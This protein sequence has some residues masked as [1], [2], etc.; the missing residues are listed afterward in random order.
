MKAMDIG[1]VYYDKFFDSMVK[2]KI[3]Y[4]QFK[5]GDKVKLHIV[6]AEH[7][8]KLWLQYGEEK[9]P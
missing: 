1:D 6:M 2:L 5:A 9:Q 8:F 3:K 4:L 7:Q